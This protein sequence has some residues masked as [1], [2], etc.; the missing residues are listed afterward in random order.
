MRLVHTILLKH[1]DTGECDKVR[2]W[3]YPNGKFGADYG[4]VKIVGYNTAKDA[5]AAVKKGIEGLL[6]PKY[7]DSNYDCNNCDK[8]KIQK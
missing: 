7:Y 8:C 4:E 2:I 5:M 1:M 3:K 6:C